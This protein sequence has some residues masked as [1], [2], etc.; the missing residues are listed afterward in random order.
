M[1]LRDKIELNETVVVEFDNDEP[2]G[3]V[4]S[5]IG[6]LINQ[7]YGLSYPFAGDFNWSLDKKFGKLPK[8]IAK[9]LHDVYDVNLTQEEKSKIGNWLSDESARDTEEFEFDIT[10]IFDWQDGDFGDSGSCFW[11]EN[12]HHRAGLEINGG[13][14]IR[15]YDGYKGFARAWLWPLDDENIAI[16]N[17]YGI[18]TKQVARVLGQYLGFDFK[19]GIDCRSSEIYINSGSCAVVGSRANDY[20]TVNINCPSEHD[21]DYVN[22][23]YRCEYCGYG[24][25]EDQICFTED[26]C[27]CEDCYHEHYFYCEKCE[28]DISKEDS[29][30]AQVKTT[31]NGYSMTMT[32]CENCAIEFGWA[33]CECCEELTE[34][35][36][37]LE[38]DGQA[39]CLDCIESDSDFIRC[40]ECGELHDKTYEIIAEYEEGWACSDCA[41]GYLYTKIGDNGKVA[42]ACCDTKVSWVD[43]LDDW[44]RCETCQEIQSILPHMANVQKK[45]ESESD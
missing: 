36:E 11:A 42:C 18:K 43:M 40:S 12:S 31:R 23:A 9:H 45:E 19:Y 16:F 21:H 24:V 7:N 29:E 8:R 33:K 10:D 37:V 28:H 4:K 13:L 2:S 41:Q 17:A 39:Y 15:F 14:A 32:M 25:S 3:F 26:S 22:D 5:Q 20:T 6:Q 35:Y 38:S 44:K 30:S 34:D 27:L 1:M